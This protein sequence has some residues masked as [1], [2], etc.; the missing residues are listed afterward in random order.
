MD[1]SSQVVVLVYFMECVLLFFSGL[2][3]G[4]YTLLFALHDPNTIMT[5]RLSVSDATE[6]LQEEVFVFTNRIAAVV[7]SFCHR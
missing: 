1:D 6:C 2:C 4:F 3:T 7:H 5:S